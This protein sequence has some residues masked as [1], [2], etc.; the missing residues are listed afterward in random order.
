MTDDAYHEGH[1]LDYMELDGHLNIVYLIIIRLAVVGCLKRLFD[2]GNNSF[3]T[4]ILWVHIT[5]SY[6]TSWQKHSVND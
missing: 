4:S 5:G 2:C 1:H 3:V 6:S